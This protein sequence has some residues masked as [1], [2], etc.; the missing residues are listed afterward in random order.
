MSRVMRTWASLALGLAMMACGSEV[1]PADGAA[2]FD[3][4]IDGGIG[5]AD[6]SVVR[7]A[8][9]DAEVEGDSGSPDAGPPPPEVRFV[10]PI[11]AW[12][13]A[14]EE[15][16]MRG[17]HSGSAD[18]AAPH[19]TPVFAARGGRVTSAR[20]TRLGGNT[21]VIDHG[22]GYSTVYS[23][24]IEPAVV[25]AG[26]VVEAGQLVGALGRTGNA[27]LNGAHLH[28]AIRRDGVRLVVPGLDYGAWIQRGE[29]IPGDY[30]ELD[31]FPAVRPSYEVE[32]VD[33][34]VPAFSGPAQSTSVVAE[35][36]AGEVLPVSRTDAGYY[37]VT[38]EDGRT[39]WVVH[40]ATTPAGV[41][42][43][44]VRITATNANVRSGPSTSEERIGTLP[45][46]T[47]VTI[48][49][50][51][52]DF[53]RLLF[54]LPTVY[55][56]THVSNTEPTEQHEARIRAPAANVR[57]GPSVSAE[58]IG[59]L[60]FTDRIIVYER[61]HGWYRIRFDGADAWV[62]GWLTGGRL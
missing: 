28:F 59:L 34:G 12:V 37:E 19:G 48:F 25:E 13:A 52:N 21:L 24:L 53:H 38:L 40:N 43:S 3:A 41:H 58:S 2:E 44:G 6:A 50:T 23:H 18:L 51:R 5:A 49:E 17:E 16:Y 11:D 45:N 60:R 9:A 54:G 27:Y 14:N 39:G 33:D 35:L 42:V 10:W 8:G 20:W 57:T 30:S 61:R 36:R 7:D 1:G 62:A 47:L 32:V 26:D 15:Y 29:A 31:T 4:A 46:G 56:W 55:A 22:E